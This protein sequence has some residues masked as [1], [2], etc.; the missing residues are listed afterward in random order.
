MED[1]I[2]DSNKRGRAWKILSWTAIRENGHGRCYPG[3][4]LERAGMEDVIP[5]SIERTDME[6]VIPDRKNVE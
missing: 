2:L 3:Q 6:V 4:Q 5:D 1:V